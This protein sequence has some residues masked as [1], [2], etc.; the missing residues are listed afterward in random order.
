MNQRLQYRR[1]VAI[2]GCA[3]ASIVAVALPG[4][5]SAAAGGTSCGSRTIA[6]SAKGGKSVT[7]PVSRIRVEGGATCQEA[8]KVIRG[9]VEHKIPNGWAV[10]PGAFQVPQGLHAEIATNGKKKVKF[11]LI[12][13]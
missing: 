7:V 11:A 6:A 13:S 1:R 3:V 4:A 9:F 12:G 5:A 2:L 10:G 8:I